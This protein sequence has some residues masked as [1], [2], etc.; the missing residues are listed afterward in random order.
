ML[1][2]LMQPKLLPSFT[3]FICSE[4]SAN[5]SS[6]LFFFLG[7]TVILGFIIRHLYLRL[8][9]A[10]LNL[11]FFFFN[12]LFFLCH[13]PRCNMVLSWII[14][15]NLLCSFNVSFSLLMCLFRTSS[16]K[17]SCFSDWT[18]TSWVVLG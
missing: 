17:T 14:L 4:T 16:S 18:K 8:M 13:N 6:L 2:V 3:Q 9:R 12:F 1:H 7:V 5:T 10:L 15:S 11:L